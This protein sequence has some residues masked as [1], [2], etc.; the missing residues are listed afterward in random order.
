MHDSVGGQPT[1]GFD[2]NF[3]KIA[4]NCGYTTAKKVTTLEG[5]NDA[6]TFAISAPGPHFLDIHVKPGNR[7]ISVD[8]LLPQPKIK[9][10]SWEM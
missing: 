3:C 2:V 9:D 8:Q 4:E 1:V 10:L 5:L 6:L 7:K